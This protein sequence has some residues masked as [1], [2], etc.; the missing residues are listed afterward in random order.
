MKVRTIAEVNEERRRTPVIVAVGKTVSEWRP[1]G[2]EGIRW[3][4]GD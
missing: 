3:D 4:R 1:T 2:I